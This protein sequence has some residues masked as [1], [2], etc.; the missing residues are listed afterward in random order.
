MSDISLKIKAEQLGKTLE[1]LSPL[2]EDE[3]NNAVKNLAHAA[4]SAMVAKI[5]SMGI[6]DKSRK[7]YLKA[8]DF[9]N[10]GDDSYLISLDGE[11]ANKLEKGFPA[12]SIRDQLLKSSKSVAVG[13]RAGEPWVR[14]SEDGHK[15]AAVPFQ[16]KAG[17]KGPTGDLAS[18][19]KNLM[20]KGVNG[21]VQPLGKVYKNAEG[22]AIN[23]KV[24]SVNSS[25]VQDP[26]LKGLTKYQYTGKSGKVS[27]VYMTFRMVSEAG[28]DWKHPGHK[29]YQL[30]KEAEDYIEQEMDQILKTLL[31]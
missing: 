30:F 28:K 27:S 24:A 8:L 31:K 25:D 12:Y 11:W 21:V 19:I 14:T 6:S 20:A 17:P 22:K 15:Y 23:G 7:D 9:H 4:Y 16:H 26:K 3:V 13:S 10:L 29:G 18:D 2:I 5:Q 1:N